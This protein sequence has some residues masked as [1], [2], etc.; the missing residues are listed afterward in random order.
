[1]YIIFIFFS[2]CFQVVSG[3]TVIDQ[4]ASE[5][6]LDYSEKPDLKRLLDKFDVVR[7]EVRL[8]SKIGF[9]SRDFPF[10]FPREFPVI[11]FLVSSEK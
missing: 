11:G 1:M 6:L 4:E 5:R 8:Q 9:L 7:V 10:P 2:S 3:E